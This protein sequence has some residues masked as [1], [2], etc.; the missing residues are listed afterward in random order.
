MAAVLSIESFLH[1][2]RYGQLVISFRVRV[3][4]VAHGIQGG[5]ATFLAVLGC[6]M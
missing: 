2:L 5:H 4:P 1:L 3:T 6:R